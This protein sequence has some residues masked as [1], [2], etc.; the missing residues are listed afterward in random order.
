MKNTF[1]S[2]NKK[3]RFLKNQLESKNE[4]IKNQLSDIDIKDR[5]NHILEAESNRLKDELKCEI[6]LK[7]FYK[8]DLK[9]Y[10]EINDKHYES[11]LLAESRCNKKS[12]HIKIL[13]I[14]LIIG[15]VFIWSVK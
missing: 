12:L 1:A 3:I 14:I 7:G 11:L 2:K 13:Y 5:T 10:M 4:I 15:S 8:S 9:A 6:S